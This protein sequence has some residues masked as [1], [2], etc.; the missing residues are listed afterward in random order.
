MELVNAIRKA[1]GIVE[2][3]PQ[4]FIAQENFNYKGLPILK[5]SLVLY[6]GVGKIDVNMIYF[7]ILQDSNVPVMLDHI[8]EP[9]NSL[10]KTLGTVSDC[11][12]EM[13]E[14]DMLDTGIWH[15]DHFDEWNNSF[16]EYLP[17]IESGVNL[18][19][20]GTY[21]SS[22]MYSF[23]SAAGI[24]TNFINVEPLTLDVNGNIV[25]LPSLLE[26]VFP[27]VPKKD[28]TL[29]PSALQPIGEMSYFG[30][31]MRGKLGIDNGGAVFGESAEEFEAKV[32]EHPKFEVITMTVGSNIV[33]LPDGTAG[34]RLKD[35]KHKVH[36]FKIER[37]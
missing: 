3:K 10:L 14:I 6:D 33:I 17:R 22:L 13:D 15:R 18:E 7:G 23:N 36:H 19:Y 25:V 30:Y 20:K 16:A 5:D 27:N 24:L 11:P 2:G 28:E 26:I 34:I 12:K 1:S 35:Q 21:F 4:L 9:K 32:F 29:Y 37:L 8:L 31:N